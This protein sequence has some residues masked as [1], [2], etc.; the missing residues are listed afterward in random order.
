M[1]Q[2]KTNFKPRAWSFSAMH[3]YE[4]CALQFLLDR[5]EPVEQELSW[6]LEHG[7]HCHTLM[8]NYLKGIIDGVP[9]ELKLFESELI[10][11]K[12]V[13]ALAEEEIVLDRHWDIVEGDN[14]WRS[15]DAW[16]RAKLDARWDNLIVDL[17]TGRE[18]DHYAEQADLYATMR[19]Q[20]DREIGEIDV[21]FWYTKSGDVASFTFMRSEQEERIEAWE[22]RARKL[23]TEKHWLPSINI[24]C[25]WCAYQERC[26]LFND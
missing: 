7:I 14:P 6:A 23:M 21:E 18:Y 8:E 11:L 12:S 1:G 9:I 19:M 20:I 3:S 22:V 15:K 2:L 24:G 16:I 4:N 25:R 13:G 10:K 17:K 26:E 5:T